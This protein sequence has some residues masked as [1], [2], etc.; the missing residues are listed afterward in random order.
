MDA[1]AVALRAA[2]DRVVMPLALAANAF[3]RV[4]GWHDFGYAR[5]D[6]HARERYGR[7]GRWLRDLASLGAALARLPRLGAAL[8]GDDGGRPIGKVATLLIGAV[9]DPE[10][11]PA[12]L[13]RARRLTVRE[14]RAEV[15]RARAAPGDADAGSAAPGSAAP[16]SAAP[17]SVLPPLDEDRVLVRVPVPAPV[18]AAFDEGVALFHAIEGRSAGATSFVEALV[19]ESLASGLAG[20]TPDPVGHSG[21]DFTGIVP[22]RDAPASQTPVPGP[23]PG[24]IEAELARASDRWRHLPYPDPPRTTG[25]ALGPARDALRRLQRLAAEP[26]EGSVVD[27][28]ARLRH[29]VALEDEL[30]AHLGDLM[31]GIARA[32]GWERLRFAGVGHYAEE[33]LGLSRT[34]GEDRARAARALRRYPLLR[35]RY[36]GGRIGLEAALLVARILDDA[37][38]GPPLERAWA[39]RAGS[40]T[41]KR[42][43]DEARLLGLRRRQAPWAGGGSGS[44][45]GPGAGRTTDPPS[46]GFGTPPTDAEWYASLLRPPGLARARV[47]ACGLATL[48][49]PARANDGPAVPDVFL[50]LRLPVTMA[51]DFLAAIESHRRHLEARA[52][53]IPPDAPWPDPAPP[54]SV[55]AARMFSIRRRRLPPWVGLLAM[56]EDFVHTWDPVHKPRPPSRDAVFVR[57][58]W[59][60]TAPGCSSRRHLEAHHLRYRSH[61]GDN[62]LAN[63]VTLCC[64]HHQRGE[65]GGLAAATGRAPLGIFWRLGRGGIGG[66]FLNERRLPSRSLTWPRG[67]PTIC[68]DL[69]GDA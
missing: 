43:R 1:M 45:A 34:T 19:A 47:L 12:W 54:P 46:P 28:D 66:R 68:R 33:R 64:F 37:H 52:G 50:R 38:A 27:L 44:G 6:D 2:L 10:S 15:A 63:L 17:D 20:L 39:D 51:G 32:G 53:A 42:L 18:L 26:G 56:L 58:G 4:S 7:S 14:L 41:I 11:L 61:G 48:G 29:L 57:D 13:A 36:R 23:A 21:Q 59:R 30:E 8:T 40:M 5:S 65:H 35:A 9:A 31:D 62:A 67:Y 55:V 22:P 3:A 69:G 60:C 25:A 49:P 24:P 16:G